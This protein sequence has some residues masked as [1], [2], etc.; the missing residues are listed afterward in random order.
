MKH[1]MQ[2]IV[3]DATTKQPR[4]TE[5]QIVV[6]LIASGTASVAKLRALPA[7]FS[8]EDWE[9]FHQLLGVPTERFFELFPSTKQKRRVTKQLTRLQMESLERGVYYWCRWGGSSTRRSGEQLCFICGT[10]DHRTRPQKGYVRGLKLMQRTKSWSGRVWILR[11][12]V[13]RQPTEPELSQIWSSGVPHCVE[14]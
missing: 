14:E 2:F 4:F 9:Q 6:Y 11:S 5:N 13:L 3:R 10:Q 7:P 12:D 8:E 1:P